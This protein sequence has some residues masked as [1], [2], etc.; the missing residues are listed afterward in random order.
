MGRPRKNDVKRDSSGKSRG[1]DGIHPETIAVR[2]R[3]L[4]NDGVVLH[5][6]NFNGVRDELRPTATDAKAGFTL[7][8]LLLFH[9]QGDVIRGINRKQFEAGEYWSSLCRRHAAIMG[10]AEWGT[11]LAVHNSQPGAQTV[12][13]DPVPRWGWGV[14]PPYQP[15]GGGEA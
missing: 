7:G 4:R 12:P 15:G 8:R 11:R 6:M 5:R 13:H 3:E 9:E 14:A 10:Y 1:Y 2:E